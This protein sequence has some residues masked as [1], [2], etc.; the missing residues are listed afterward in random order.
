MRTCYKFSGIVT[1]LN[2]IKIMGT[3]DGAAN[4]G[5]SV[6]ILKWR[7]KDYRAAQIVTSKCY[8]HQVNTTGTRASGTSAHKVNLNPDLGTALSRTIVLVRLCSL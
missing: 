1:K 8:A 3:V 2:V 6:E 4:A 5:K 7:T